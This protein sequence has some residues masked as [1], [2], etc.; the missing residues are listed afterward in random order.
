MAESGGHL[1]FPKADIVLTPETGM[2][3]FFS[4]KSSAGPEMDDGYTETTGCP[5]RAGGL[6]VASL[7]MRSGVPPPSS[8]F[9][10]AGAAAA[11]ASGG[12][13]LLDTP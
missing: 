5:V 2:G 12:A 7:H 11:A 9:A 4:Y 10:V 3:V 6:T 1:T 8:A 13:V